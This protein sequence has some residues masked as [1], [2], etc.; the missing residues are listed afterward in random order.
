MACWHV[1][2]HNIGDKFHERHCVTTHIA[3]QNFADLTDLLGYATCRAEQHVGRV[4]VE[5]VTALTLFGQVTVDDWRA[6]PEE[7]SVYHVY[8]STDRCKEGYE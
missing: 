1:I 6:K 7:F 2:F 3:Y 4:R 5:G 8:Y